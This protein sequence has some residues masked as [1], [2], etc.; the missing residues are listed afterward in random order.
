MERP[1]EGSL[2]RHGQLWHPVPAG[3]GREDESCATDSVDA[4]VDHALCDHVPD[5]GKGT[6]IKGSLSWDS[7]TSAA[8]SPS[9]DLG[10]GRAGPPDEACVISKGPCIDTHLHIIKLG[11]EEHKWVG[12]GKIRRQ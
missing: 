10:V 3:H 12:S 5:L 7:S 2:H 11:V 1:V 9:A 4:Q 6:Q 8:G